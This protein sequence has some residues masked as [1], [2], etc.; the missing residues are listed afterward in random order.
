MFII[1]LYF[2]YVVFLVKW[3]ILFDF[4]YF[5]KELKIEIKVCLS[6]FNVKIKQCNLDSDDEYI[7]YF[8]IKK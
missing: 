6:S 7:G 3:D 4:N 8:S 1:H 2:I 5:L